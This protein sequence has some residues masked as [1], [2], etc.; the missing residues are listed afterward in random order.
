MGTNR[1]M[2]IVWCRV[3]RKRHVLDPDGSEFWI[4][5]RKGASDISSND[6]TGLIANYRGKRGKTSSRTIFSWPAAAS[7]PAVT[8]REVAAPADNLSERPTNLFCT[9]Y[10]FEL[11]PCILQRQIALFVRPLG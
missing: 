2:T 4:T 6:I 10:K 1:A 7:I 9:S 3:F 5:V 11:Q 8:R